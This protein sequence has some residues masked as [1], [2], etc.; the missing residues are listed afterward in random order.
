[1]SRCL[2]VFWVA[3]L[4]ALGALLLLS[5]LVETPQA[6]AAAP[7]ELPAARSVTA[8]AVMPPA[9][10]SAAPS[11]MGAWLKIAG[12]FAVVVLLLPRLNCTCDANGR[13]LCKRRYAR[14]FY[15]VFRQDLA[16]G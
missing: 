14:S 7:A 3:L 10:A 11:A 2:F 1:M 12:L 15:P 4:I 5:A 9:P 8:F 13:V 16:C 6:E